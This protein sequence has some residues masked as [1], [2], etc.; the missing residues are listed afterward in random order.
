MSE[1]SA[2]LAARGLR[3]IA[4]LAQNREHGDRLRYMAGCRCA[5]CRRANTDYEKARA[6]ARKAGD[7]NGIVP[8]AAARAHMALLSQGGVGRRVVGDV[9]G[10]ADSVLTEIIAG[11]KTR[12]RARTERAIV[13]VTVKAAADRAYID[14][15]PTWKLIDEL[16]VDGFSKAEL[17]RLLGYLT[18]ALQLKRYQITVRNAYDVEQLHARLRS[19]DASETLALLTDLSEEGFHRDRVAKQMAVLAESNGLD[20]PDLTVRR[21]RIRNSA[22]RLVAQLHAELTA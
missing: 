10:V 1:I 17:A 6:L 14:G 19:C 13:A 2:A 11:R 8:A 22:A 7:W 21:G 5:D 12:I 18:P 9:S 20:A 3:P 4:E 15:A 16:L